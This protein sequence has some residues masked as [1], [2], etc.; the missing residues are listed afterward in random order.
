MESIV[1]VDMT[2]VGWDNKILSGSPSNRLMDSIGHARWCFQLQ[3]KDKRRLFFSRKLL[4]I[5]RKLNWENFHFSIPFLEFTE[6][7]GFAS[8]N[9]PK[10]KD[11]KPWVNSPLLWAYD[12]QVATAGQSLSWRSFY[13]LC[14]TWLINK[15]GGESSEHIIRISMRFSATCWLQRRSAD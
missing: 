1:G 13:G 4:A 14:R 3:K 5:Q 8:A 9:L 12:R 15:T 6:S 2:T 7:C 11:A 10:G